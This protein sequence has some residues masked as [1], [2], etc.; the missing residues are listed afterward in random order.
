[1]RDD[2]N[3]KARR[4]MAVVRPIKLKITNYPDDMQENFQIENN[5]ENMDEGFRQVSFSNELWIES[6]DFRPEKVK[7]YRRLFPGNEVRLKSAYVVKCTGFEE[8]ENGQITVLAE[9]DPL[10]QGGVTP[11]GRKIRSTIHWVNA[12]DC[13]DFEARLYDQ[14][15]TVDE[16][17]SQEDDLLE[18]LNPE[19]L[20]VISNC[21]GEPSIMNPEINSFQFMRLGYFHKDLKASDKSTLPVFNRSVSLKDSFKAPAL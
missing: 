19:S 5:P 15:F 16:P 13:V 1:L 11:D 6:D 4:A 17:D 2:L 9:Y 7:G 18:Y 12:K 3:A 8:D 10:T 14:L 20:E 21:K